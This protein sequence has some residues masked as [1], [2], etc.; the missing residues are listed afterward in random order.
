MK[1]NEKIDG[2]NKNLSKDPFE[3]ID[4]YIAN[5][6][7]LLDGD[8]KD[9]V[10]ED[11]AEETAE[12]TESSEDGDAV[13]ET[14]EVSKEELTQEE[15]TVEEE[16]STKAQETVQDENQVQEE[17]EEKPYVVMDKKTKKDKKKKHYE[18]DK[19]IK[20]KN[21]KGDR[22]PAAVRTIGI[23][24]ILL[25]LLG[26]TLMGFAIYQLAVK[27]SYVKENKAEDIVYPYLST[28]T[29]VYE[30]IE[31]LVAPSSDASA[32]DAEADGN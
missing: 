24:A 1:D 7:K 9:S 15:N 32:T 11:V 25:V 30:P 22:A 5:V 28:N 23:I 26:G 31:H 21:L 19:E 20:Q 2:L 17:S 6:N 4:A 3:D 8:K 10:D 16:N 12:K 18:I 29:D 14:S 13:E 27:P